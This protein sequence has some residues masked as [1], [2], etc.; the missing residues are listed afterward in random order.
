[1]KAQ[2]ALVRRYWAMFPKDAWVRNGISEPGQKLLEMIEALPD[3]K[4]PPSEVNHGRCDAK[5]D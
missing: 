1:L 3:P 5:L 4:Q 2:A